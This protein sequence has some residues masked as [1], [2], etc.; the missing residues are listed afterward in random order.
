MIDF[1]I[2]S[3]NLAIVAMPFANTQAILNLLPAIKELDI[4]KVHIVTMNYEDSF[5]KDKIE[6]VVSNYWSVAFL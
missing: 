2:K 6:F 1:Y 3:E 4:K 5:V